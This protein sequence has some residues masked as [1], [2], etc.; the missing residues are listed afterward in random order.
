MAYTI[1]F[2]KALIVFLGIILSVYSLS[3]ADSRDRRVDHRFYRYRD[4]PH[5]GVHVDILP[6]RY[7]PIWSG[8]QRYYYSDGLYYSPYGREYVIVSPPVGAY[9]STIPSEFSPIVINGTTYYTNNGFYYVYT[10][11]GY[12]AVSPPVEVYKAFTVNV[13]NAQGE[14]TQIV[15][16]KSGN[17]F[18]GPQGEYYPEF[19]KVFQLEIMYGT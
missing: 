15:I 7:S 2:K 18:T 19:P 8:R 16:K 11:K 9:V 17:G 6:N 1:D 12:Q 13:P 3:Y 14:Y 10:P 5:F 4:H